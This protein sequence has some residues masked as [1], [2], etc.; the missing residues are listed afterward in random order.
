MVKKAL[1]I[2][3]DLFNKY[4][5]RATIEQMS[6]KCWDYSS[7]LRTKL[8]CAQ[9]CLFKSGPGGLL[10]NKELENNVSLKLY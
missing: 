2:K 3:I 1:C 8:S 5:L 6:F 4:L 10:I 7:E 9:E